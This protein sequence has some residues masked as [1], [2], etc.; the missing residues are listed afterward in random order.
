MAE[1]A[2]H[3]DAQ[4]LG[5]LAGEIR[6]T[7]AERGDF[8]WAD[9]REVQGVEE[10]NHVLAA[11]LRQGDVLELLI[12]HSSGGEVRGL[13]ANAQAAVRCHDRDEKRVNGHPC[14]LS[15]VVSTTSFTYQFITFAASTS[16]YTSFRFVV[17]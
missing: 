3:R 8:G 10:Q 5:V 13:L 6:V 15:K 7:V 12:N 14:D 4:D 2:V 9:E 1:L 11:V 17:P 16:K